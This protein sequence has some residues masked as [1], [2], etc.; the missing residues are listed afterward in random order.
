[1]MIKKRLAITTIAVFIIFINDLYPQ[2]LSY[3]LSRVAGEYAQSYLQPFINSFGADLNSGFYSATSSL[4]DRQTGFHLSFGLKTIGAFV[5]AN[6]KTFSAVYYDTVM[7][8]LYGQE[9]P[10]SGKATVKDA[11]T[12]FGSADPAN[13]T[14]EI[15][16]T[17]YAALIAYPIHETRQEKTI[18]GLVP[19]D[20]VPL[21]VPQLNIGTYMGTD[22]FLRWLPS[23]KL[24]SY[25]NTSFI[26]FGIEHNLNQYLPGLPVNIDL[27]FSYQNMGITDTTG[28][29]FI[30]LNA[31]AVDALVNKALGIVNVYGAVQYESENLDV[32]YKYIPQNSNSNSFTTNINFSLKGENTFRLI[33]GVSVSL[34][35]FNV[36]LDYNISKI[37]VLSLGLGFNIL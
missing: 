22:I 37:N 32:N 15:N 12:I 17:I 36:N 20:F 18:G 11:P 16:D 14:V 31:L 3:N 23:I 30:N 5:P 33:T 6:E 8:N 34:G 19:T 10:V 9:Y 25:G 4:A 29:R 2:N 7:Y 1:M 24:G 35:I 28:Y 13:A 27:L 26:G 21:V